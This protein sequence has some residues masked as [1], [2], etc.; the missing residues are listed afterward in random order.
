MGSSHA[1]I[2]ARI[3][4]AGRARDGTHSWI[5]SHHRLRPQITLRP[6]SIDPA[7][8]FDDRGAI[9]RTGRNHPASDAALDDAVSGALHHQDIAIR[10][11]R[12]A[13]ASSRSD[14]SR[15]TRVPAARRDPERGRADRG[16]AAGPKGTG[17]RPGT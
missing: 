3:A 16:H 11:G 1:G 8:Q 14:V 15:E 12:P 4:G 6:R 5:R 10:Q 2:A 7:L 13:G 9:G 17:V